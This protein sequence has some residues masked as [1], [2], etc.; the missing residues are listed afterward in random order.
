MS[1][2]V[3]LVE[4]S[5]KYTNKQ[6][7]AV[8][9]VID[10]LSALEKVSVHFLPEALSQLT[11]A[12]VMSAELLIEGFQHGSFIEDTLVK[13]IFKNKEEMD[14]FLDKVREG[15]RNVYRNLPGNGSPVLKGAVAVTCVI[16]ALV[17]AGAGWAIINKSPPAPSP[18]SLSI[19]DS[20]FVIIGAE[21]YAISPEKFADVIEKVGSTDKKKL[22]QAA[23]KIIAPAKKE[24]GATVVMSQDDKLAIPIETVKNTPDA[25]EFE[26]FE[27]DEPHPDAD[28]EIRATDLDSLS[29]GW[30]A[31]IRG[32]V[33]RR[34]K[35]VLDEG[36]DPQSL[37]GKFKVRADV[38][39]KFRM[40]AKTKKMEP[41]SITVQRIIED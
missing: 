4:H 35:L 36:V 27:I 34:V 18:I 13:L 21:S 17:A 10:S 12:G 32:L 33:D 24:D 15:G 39:V 7:L 20:S 37:A 40:S 28:V 22:A 16:G 30:A 14:K 5:V 23:V 41:V 11:G 2:F 19:T 1:E 6:P 38:I 9:D 25:V 8:Q 3:L 26:P 31:I 29:R